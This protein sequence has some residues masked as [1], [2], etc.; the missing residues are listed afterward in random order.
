[1]YKTLRFSLVSLLIMLC[2]TVM[3]QSWERT[4]TLTVGDV[5][6]LA[7]DNGTVT[8][9]LS[10]V[11][12]TGTTIG[13][14][15][16]YD[17]TPAGAYPLT[18][19][20]GSAEG[21]VA[22][23]TSA[24]TYLSW[25]SGNS[26]TTR[27]E[28]AEASSWTVSFDNDGKASIV[29]VGTPERILQYNANS[30]RFACYGNS[31]QTKP[32]F[33]KQVAADMLAK[34][35][36]TASTTF[37]GEMTVEITA[38]E[39]A[40][41]YYTT[42]GTEPTTASTKYTA[43][44]TINATTTVKA[45]ASLNDQTSSV[46]EATYT[47]LEKST[48]AEAQAAEAGT[49]V[50]VEGVVVASAAN[51]AV[52]SDGTDYL[53]Y[54]NTSNALNVGQKVRMIGALSTYGGAK[55]LP[56]TA[57]IT[58][59]GEETVS[60][61]AATALTG[62]DMDA[63]YTAK[64]AE[65]KYVTFDGHLSINGNYY[66][67]TVDGA[68]TAVGSIVKPKEDL[69]ALDD[70]DVTVKGYLM[71]VNNKYVYVIATSVEEKVAVKTDYTDY[72]VNATLTGEGGFDA[73]GTK[74]IDGSGIVKV[75][76]A[77]TFDF[78]Q[79]IANLPAGQYKL[80][81]Q[82]AYRYSGSEQAEYDAIQAGT[83]TKYAM[84]YA[85][86]GT[87]TVLQPVMNRYDGASETD[88]AAGNGSVQ[89]NGLYVPNSSAAVQTWFNAGKYVNE[90]V[91]NLPEDGSVKIGI[92][93]TSS[94]DA[95]DYTVLGP[96]T[97]T[98]LGDA[99]AE[100]EP[101]PEPMLA[102]GK[103]YIEN[104]ASHLFWGAAN[105]WGT[106]AS[107][108]KNADYVTLAQ[109]PN[110]NYTMESQVSNGGTN[111]Y[112]GGDYMDGQPVEL[113]ITKVAEG[114]YTIANG[115]NYY[116]WDGTSNILGKNLAADSE[117]ALWIISTE[118]DMMANLQKA[119]ADKPV[120]AT[121]LIA[122]HTFG[123]NNR[124]VSAWSNEGSAALTGGNSNKHCA[125]KYHG[126]FNVSQKLTKAPAG[127]YKFTAQGF[128]RQDGEDNDNL[129]VFYANNATAQF[130]VKTGSENSMAD[131]CTSF[132]AGL[133]QA[134]PVYVEVTEAGEL[135]IGAKLETNG[136]L[137]CIW[138]NFELTYYG[139]EANIDQLKNAALFA[140]VD[141][142]RNRA[143]ELS[144]AGIEVEAVKTALQEA[145]AATAE[146]TTAEQ[147][148]AA[149]ET[150]TAAID[151]AEASLTA[152]A[153][154]ANVNALVEATNVY[155]EE[156]YN[157]YNAYYTDWLAKYN[158]GTLTKAEANAIE[159][160]A[161]I[162]GWHANVIVDN[163]LLSAWDTNPDFQ[164]AAY[165]IN[166]WSVEGEN[167]GSEFKVPFFE[168][169]TGDG[170]S[171]G[172]KTL[173]ATMN[174]LETGDYDVTA[175]VRVRMKNG[176]EAPATGITFQANDGEAVNASDGAQVGTSQFFLKEVTA[177]GTVAEDGVLKIKFNVAAENNISWLSFKNV[178]F[179]KHIPMISGTIDFQELCMKLGKGG[180]WAVNDGGD[181]GFKVNDADMHFLGDYDEQGFQWGKRFAYEYN[182]SKGNAQKFTFRNKNN[183]KDNSCGL[184][185]W[186][187]D[188]NFSILGLK[189]G[190]KV[191]I[192]TLAGT[193]TFVS[194]NVTDEVAAG[195]TVESNK[196]Y[197]IASGDR[198][199]ISM[200][201]ATLI[202]KIVIEPAGMEVVPTIALDRNTLALVPGATQKLTASVDPASAATVWKSSDE[203]VATIAEDGTVTAV[204]AGTANITIT[205]KSEQSD[206]A[207]EA[208]CVVTVADVDF[209]KYQVVK[210]YDFTTMGSVDLTIS[211]EAA[212]NIWNQ[213]NNKTN[214]VYFC[215]NE[216]L[217]EIAVQAVAAAADGKGWLI[218]EEGL[219][220]AK[221]AGRCA[222]I[223]GIKT[224]QIVEFFYTGDSFYTKSDDDGIEK[225]ALNEAI[226]RAIYQASED[227]MIG[228]ELNKG[229]AI[230]KINVYAPIADAIS[231][232]KTISTDG[233][234]FN[235]NGQK[236]EK[237]QKGLYIINGKKVVIK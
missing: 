31:N 225:T 27:E 141:E 163:F 107:L 81:A 55:Q 101:E 74:G 232:V 7:V 133:Y 233:A 171:L 66:N 36:L 46:A 221:G 110:G 224:N 120:D 44:L 209:T 65:R 43:P 198:L 223:G 23:K 215:T 185:S 18:V 184:F 14:V 220:L 172:E 177:T 100:P 15:A 227:G 96:W 154:F 234:V 69:S 20:A 138:D 116:G 45:I 153:T 202:S 92:V 200:A 16:D 56:N 62:A 59:L 6:V 170:E 85:T 129:P 194:T 115:T 166:T 114:K 158:D 176:A 228:F 102:D 34:P 149:V 76:S 17:G 217:E 122:D 1:M 109:L 95:G 167:D 40:D 182:T 48:L 146:V 87:K 204:A 180:P 99:E 188:H 137:W 178:K 199:D 77:A 38:A 183:K 12:T 111:Y 121:F 32:I 83:D 206:A 90:L 37:C 175:W 132:E 97:L 112:F 25:T 155:T 126:T 98:R 222:A 64:V 187:F 70:K 113:T 237:A 218:T 197:T 80:T 143:T 208:T 195:A 89:V 72:I 4:S 213:A 61:P 53:Y 86:V 151:K 57:A 123:R 75:G 148:T 9:E 124:N 104:I 8:K 82:A 139:T 29:N 159:N 67:I 162:T 30:P 196:T 236:V 210:A 140:Q 54:Y 2:G 118:E 214:A 231:T 35:T 205:W 212:G 105:D 136:T 211:G 19:V 42:D 91:F 117:N 135:T 164:D 58:L 33:W 142:L 201:K 165:Y 13:Q 144:N 41:I 160:P 190:D 192:T 11:T 5:V 93:K 152:K 78:T 169:W 230:T 79:T 50:A 156:A 94:P 106:R 119:T 68:E 21:S 26:L 179:E 47:A 226:G 71:Y 131:A 216:G 22:F 3:A 103:Y 10:G 88:L 174:N 134:D 52:L 186:D 147:A 130:P 127:I 229:N 49:T 60:H 125:E 203:T 73:T 51:G 168:Y 189:E 150:L 108:L 235:L 84:L 161:T 193:T 63:I 39:G 145:L 128:Y 28:V 173:T 157:N 24:N 181:A 207:V 191:T 219:Y